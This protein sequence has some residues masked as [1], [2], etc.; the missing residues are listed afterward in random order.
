MNSG[1]A[2]SGDKLWEDDHERKMELNHLAAN[3]MIVLDGYEVV[4]SELLAFFG[5]LVGHFFSDLISSSHPADMI[6]LV[7]E[8]FA[9]KLADEIVDQLETQKLIETYEKSIL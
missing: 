9:K 1:W 4:D 2:S 7:F 8:D 5:C 6:Q 3:L